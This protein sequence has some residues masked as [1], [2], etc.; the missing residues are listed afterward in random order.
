MGGSEQ[1]NTGRD[2][3]RCCASTEAEAHAVHE[4]RNFLL[5]I[6]LLAAVLWAVLAWFVL[7]L[8][9]A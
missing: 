2:P 9:A 6:A 4:T 7:G 1:S 5:V 8:D 3:V